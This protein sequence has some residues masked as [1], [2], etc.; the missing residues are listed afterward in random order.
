[1]TS[2][3][4]SLI[5]YFGAPKILQCDNGKEFVNSDVDRLCEEFRI[6]RNS[7]CQGIRNHKAKLKGL[8]KQF[9]ECFKKFYLK[10]I[11]KEG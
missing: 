3:L 4:K 10:I 9:A 5:F 2:N 11:K 7:G 6:L 1:M 8:I